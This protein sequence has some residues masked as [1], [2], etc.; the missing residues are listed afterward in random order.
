MKWTR[1]TEENIKKACLHLAYNVPR[2]CFRWENTRLKRYCFF[3]V[4]GFAGTNNGWIQCTV[5][6]GWMNENKSECQSHDFT[7]KLLEVI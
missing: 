3:A 6:K 2:K 5:L 7:K 1:F 4:G